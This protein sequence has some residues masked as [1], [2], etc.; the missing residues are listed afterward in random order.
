MSTEAMLS[1]SGR[2]VD[3][4]QV[5]E[6][7]FCEKRWVTRKKGGERIEEEVEG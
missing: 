5:N 1:M 7:L 6:G 3:R 4:M 2:L